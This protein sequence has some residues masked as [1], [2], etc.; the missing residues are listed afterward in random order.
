MSKSTKMFSPK[1]R[2][3]AVRLV[4]DNQ[5]QDESRWLAVLSISSKFGWALQSLNDWLNMAEIDGTRAEKM[6]EMRQAK[7]LRV[8]QSK[9]A[10]R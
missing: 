4:L 10:T 9:M 7:A 3:R 1:G 2:D 6:K 5:G 8:C